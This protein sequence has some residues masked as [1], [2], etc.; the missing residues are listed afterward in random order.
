[1]TPVSNIQRASPSHM[2]DYGLVR[3]HR[4]ASDYPECFWGSQAWQ[5]HGVVDLPVGQIGFCLPTEDDDMEWI[6]LIVSIYID[7][8]QPEARLTWVHPQCIEFLSEEELDKCA[9]A[10]GLTFGRGNQCSTHDIGPPNPGI[11]QMS[12]QLVLDARWRSTFD[13]STSCTGH[14]LDM[15]LSIVN[16]PQ[17][18]GQILLFAATLVCCNRPGLVC[19]KHAKHRSLAVGIALSHLFRLPVDMSNCSRDRTDRCCRS[20]A[21]DNLDI[22]LSS[23]RT[24]PVL[25]SP[26]YDLAT[27]L[28]LPS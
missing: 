5:V 16:V 2:S 14:C 6:P 22:L 3:V 28:S 12:S 7:G 4:R 1:M 11:R 15:F 23:L 17:Q 27:S 24:L 10:I 9:V 8:G 13:G 18:F 20:R 21:I 19:C 25:V 26:D